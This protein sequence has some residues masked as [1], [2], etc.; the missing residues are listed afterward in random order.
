MQLSTLTIEERE[1]LAYV[2]G[3]TEA[4][5]LLARL[6]DCHRALAGA[7]DDYSNATDELHRLQR[8]LDALGDAC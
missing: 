8:R 3:Y 2:E 4:A 6:D 5:A 1:R 7:L